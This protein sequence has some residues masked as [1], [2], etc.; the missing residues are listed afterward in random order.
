MP[1][2]EM[3]VSIVIAAA[4]LIAIALLLR[5]L[6]IRSL[7]RTV[8]VA[9]ENGSP[10][11]PALIARLGQ[12]PRVSLKLIAY[13]LLAITAAMIGVGALEGDLADLKEA[14]VAAL[15]PGFVGA[16]ILLYLR[17]PDR[18]PDAMGDG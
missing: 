2:T 12:R 5:T 17:A 3:I 4:I 9:I 18:A 1:L 8:T 6:N 14:V 10:D 15:F 13:V 16:A 11:A 7:H